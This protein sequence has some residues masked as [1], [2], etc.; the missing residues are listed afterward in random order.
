LEAQWQ[1]IV[2]E[3]SSDDYIISQRYHEALSDIESKRSKNFKIFTVWII[4]HLFDGTAG[5]YSH[6]T[7]A[8]SHHYINGMNNTTRSYA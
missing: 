3:T 6:F 7:V 4:T 5:Y 8:W 2:D 1:D